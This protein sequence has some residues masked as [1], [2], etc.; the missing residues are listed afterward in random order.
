METGKE[1][2]GF[3]RG[4]E[5]REEER[6]EGGVLEGREEVEETLGG[7]GEDVSIRRRG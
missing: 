1:E 3:R 6:E 5:E 4:K 7:R 2:W